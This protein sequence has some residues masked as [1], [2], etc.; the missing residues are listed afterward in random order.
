MQRFVG[1]LGILTRWLL[2]CQQMLF[3]EDLF[4][5]LSAGE[6]LLLSTALCYCRQG[7]LTERA[8]PGLPGASLDPIRARELRAS[9]ELPR[10]AGPH[11]Q[12]V[13]GV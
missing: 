2:S 8:S 4:E 9:N 3:H 12:P 13:S 10:L 6:T 5:I 1:H 11:D 7:L